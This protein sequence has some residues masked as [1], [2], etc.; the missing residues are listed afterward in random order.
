MVR[1]YA[2][3]SIFSPSA[4]IFASRTSRSMLPR[5]SRFCMRISASAFISSSIGRRCAY[6]LRRASSPS[7]MAVTLLYVMRFLE[8][9][10][11]SANSLSTAFPFSSTF[12]RQERV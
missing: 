11:P 5:L 4:T 9:M 3:T 2:E 1:S 8:Q 12:I 7:K 10:T 6:S